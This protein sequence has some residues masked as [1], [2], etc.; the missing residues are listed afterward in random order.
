MY[1][2]MLKLSVFRICPVLLKMYCVSKLNLDY[3]DSLV[4]VAFIDNNHF[5]LVF[6][7]AQNVTIN[8]EDL[9]ARPKKFNCTIKTKLIRIND[10]PNRMTNSARK[11][12]A[13]S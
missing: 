6:C 11:K 5:L 3:G 8:E 1:G 7:K 10:L 4:H 12:T 2:N 13:K 9:L